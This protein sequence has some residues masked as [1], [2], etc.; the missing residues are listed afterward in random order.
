M[1]VGDWI[2]VGCWIVVGCWMLDVGGWGVGGWGVGHLVNKRDVEFQLCHEI[3][4]DLWFM[5][6]PLKN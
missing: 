1:G 2:K 4:F 6:T 3:Y 5:N